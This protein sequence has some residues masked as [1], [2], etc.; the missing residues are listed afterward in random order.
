VIEDL[1]QPTESLVSSLEEI[2]A[3][4]YEVKTQIRHVRRVSS[5]IVV[6]DIDP[7]IARSYGQEDALVVEEAKESLE[8]ESSNEEYTISK[9]TPSSS[10]EEIESASELGED[11]L[12][13]PFVAQCGQ[14]DIKRSLNFQKEELG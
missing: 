4:I 11:G 6:E 8:S 12:N 14:N 13:T 7:E 3:E 2:V 9:E 5:E 1:K 10:C